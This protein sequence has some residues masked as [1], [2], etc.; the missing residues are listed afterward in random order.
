MNFTDLP[1]KKSYINKG[2]DNFVDS[3]L[4]PA[5]KLAVCYRRSVAFFSSSVFKLLKNALPSF[6]KNKGIIQ[7]IVSLFLHQD[8]I[9]AI[10][11][12]YAKKRDVIKRSFM[13]KFNTE[14]RY[15]D[16]SS[17]NIL[18]ELIARGIL[19]IKVVSVKNNIGIY[20]DKLGILT[21]KNNN[22]IV[23]YGSA[24][25]SENA[26]QNNYEKIRVV[27]SWIKEDGDSVKDEIVEFD[28]LWNNETEFLDT[29]DFMESIKK[30]I[31]EVISE[32]NKLK[33]LQPPITLYD[34]QN[35]AIEAWVKN[36]Y[37]GFYVMATGTGK[38]WTAIYSAKKLLD[39][40]RCLLVIAAPYKHLI[41]QWEE[42][43]KKVFK[44]ATIVLISSENPQWYSISKQMMI[45]Q[46]YN[47]NRQVILIT[48]IKS[49]YS[50]RFDD[51][52]N[53][54]NL[55]KLLIVDE[56]HKFTQRPDELHT[57]YK[58]MLGLSA[59]PLNGKNNAEGKDLVHFFGG[60]V[61]NL[62]IETAL[63]KGFLVPYYYHPIF[64]RSTAEEEE[65]FNQL[66]ANMAACYINNVLVDKEKLVKCI[67]ARLR[68]LSRAEEKIQHIDMLL[69]QVQQ[70]DHYV[71]YCGDGRL[72]D[73]ENDEV[74]YIEFVKQRLDEQG[75]KTS[76]FTASEDMVRRME[77]V[78]MF[79]KN[80]ISALVAIRCLDE[81]INIPSIRSALILSSNDDYREF[82]QRRGRILRKYPGKNHA[83]IYDVIVL[84]SQHMSKMAIIE[85]RRYYEYAKL[86][87]NHQ[88]CLRELDYL[89]D[90]YLLTRD[91][92]TF[93]TEIDTE[94]DLDE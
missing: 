85:L 42:D 30:C 10:E 83:D 32:R 94:D 18:S 12:G 58:Y 76:Q 62:P 29:Y 68:I 48:T 3:L 55:D 53:M 25:S 59:T 74:R 43:V 17:L 80:E 50:D 63:E 64:V 52:I 90:N 7:L 71:V 40:K 84:P 66:S 87:M 79:N 77:L 13:A 27:R 31:V 9:N 1:I 88:D 35:E 60:Q 6:I 47:P 37:K 38:T 61:F 70:K 51:V 14:I 4:N 93:Y 11:L 69:N 72:F 24:N 78:D 34:Y 28:K 19:D 2:S 57:V 23:F 20:H 26:Y 67:R 46:Q 15:F 65:R 22:H 39:E 75:V 54:S 86:S 45:S 44:D 91:D 21:D 49:F 89:L 56:A 33:T 8:D 92:V 73:H 36:G 5:L 81:G 82:V 16:D 41:K